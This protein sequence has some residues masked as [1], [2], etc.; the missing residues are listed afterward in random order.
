M[1]ATWKI[2]RSYVTSILMLSIANVATPVALAMGPTENRTLY[3]VLHTMVR[4]ELGISLED[5]RIVSDQESASRAICDRHRNEQFFCLRHFLV[6]LKVW[7]D[8][9]G[10]LVRCRVLPDSR[11]LCATYKIRFA[12][13]LLSPQ[14]PVARWMLKI[15]DKVRFYFHM[16]RI[17]IQNSQKWRSVSMMERVAVKLPSTS[18]GFESFHGHGNEATPRRNEF[19]PSLARIASMMIR[20]TLSFRPAFEDNFGVMIRIARRRAKHNG[21]AL[22]ARRVNMVLRSSIAGPK[23]H[24]FCPLCIALPAH[25]V[26]NIHWV[27]RSHMFQS[28]TW[29]FIIQWKTQT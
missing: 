23:K 29:I 28:F 20:K 25:V 14:S 27:R 7:S 19:I 9:I 2:I 18:N 10:N 26:A 12:E 8:A 13:A 1:D 15:L 22:L 24:V 11:R 17:T 16:G 4:E 5:H 21:P 3:E 6:S